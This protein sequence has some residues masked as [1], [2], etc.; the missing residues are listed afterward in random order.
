[1]SIDFRVNP[2][3]KFCIEDLNKC[4]ENN[5]GLV[6]SS[7]DLHKCTPLKLKYYYYV[8]KKNC[9]KLK[10]FAFSDKFII[11]KNRSDYNKIK[12]LVK[13]EFNDVKE[14]NINIKFYI[15]NDESDDFNSSA[16]SFKELKFNITENIFIINLGEYN[17]T[18]TLEIKN[19]ILETIKKLHV[20]GTV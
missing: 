3:N 4:N 17:S 6:I 11:F 19:I 14:K 7:F 13:L 12:F 9:D 20:N 1:M 10:Y 8:I 16:F 5:I 15:D 2:F 18:N